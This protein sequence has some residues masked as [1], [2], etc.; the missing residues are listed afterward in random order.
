MSK[1][2]TSMGPMAQRIQP[3]RS[4]VTPLKVEG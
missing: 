3:A 1:S 4:W 2:N